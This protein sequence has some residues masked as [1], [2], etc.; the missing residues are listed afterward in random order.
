MAAPHPPQRAGRAA[1]GG[2]RRPWFPAAAPRRGRWGSHDTRRPAADRPRARRHLRRLRRL[3]RGAGDRAVPGAAGGADRDRQRRER[4][5]V[6]ADRLGQ[7]PRRDRRPLRRA[8]PRRGHVLH[9][10]DQGPGLGEVLRAL[11]HLRRRGRRHAHRRRERQ[12]RRADHLL[13]GRGAGQHRA[14]RGPARRRGAGGDGR[15]PL[16]LRARPGLGLAGAAARAA[17]GP[18]RPDVR[19]AGGRRAVPERPDPSY[20]P[21]HR[22]RHLRR[23]AGAAVLQLRPH[24]AAGDARGAAHHPPGAR[25]RRPLHPGRGAGAGPV[26]AEHHRRHPRGAR[27]DRR[28]HRRLPLRAR[29]RQAALPPGPSRHRRPPR[30]D[31]AQVPPAGRAARPGRAAEGHLRHRH[32]GRRDQRADPHGRL[33]RAVQVRRQPPAHPQGPRVPPDRRPGRPGRLR[34]LGHRRGAGPRPRHRERAGA[35]QGR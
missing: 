21:A 26:A 4:H 8:G 10:A 1:P 29:L 32:P 7:E 18:V 35:G 22:R 6:H 15:V 12:R 17:P 13:H 31:A 20:R 16:L 30:R 19:H 11:R 14:A 24:P 9:R 27:Q 5:P 25:V 34:H 33:H 3:G 2:S 23:P 28:G